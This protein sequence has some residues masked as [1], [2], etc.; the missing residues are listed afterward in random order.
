MSKFKKGDRVRIVNPTISKD[1]YFI[2]DT[3]TITGVFVEDCSWSVDFDNR[4]AIDFGV[5]TGEMELIMNRLA[6]LKLK[7]DVTNEDGSINKEL[8]GAIE[9]RLLELGGFRL[10]QTKMIGWGAIILGYDGNCEVTGSN[11]HLDASVLNDHTLSTLDDLYHLPKTH[12]ITIDGKDVELS[13]ESF[14]NLR[15]QLV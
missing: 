10:S 6:G 5:F 2:G 13:H 15:E 11:C 8:S 12:T 9:S 14:E 1:K 3:G 7:F 4:P